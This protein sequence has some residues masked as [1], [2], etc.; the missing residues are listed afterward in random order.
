[1]SSR[2]QSPSRARHPAG[3][4][5]SC[6]EYTLRLI[7][8]VRLSVCPLSRTSTPSLADKQTNTKCTLRQRLRSLHYGRL[9]FSRVASLRVATHYRQCVLTLSVATF[10]K[11]WISAS[12]DILRALYKCTIVIML[13]SVFVP[14]RSCGAALQV[15]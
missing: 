14:P 5:T 13:P 7:A 8:S 2:R 10:A 15:R 3:S 1:M 9:D 6:C 4:R 11:Y 12:E